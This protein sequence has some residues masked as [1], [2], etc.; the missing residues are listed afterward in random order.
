MLIVENAI[1]CGGKYSHINAS[2]DIL[3]KDTL[4]VCLVARITLPA[5]SLLIHV[6]PSQAQMRFFNVFGSLCVLSH[7]GQ[8]YCLVAIS[9]LRHAS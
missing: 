3:W 5:L 6:D 1:Q 2:I 8:R 9:L 7:V 4:R